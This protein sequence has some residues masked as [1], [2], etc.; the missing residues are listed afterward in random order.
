MKKLLI[1][2]VLT[3]IGST[4]MAQDL[5]IKGNVVDTVNKLPLADAVVM[6]VRLSDSVLLGFKRT[7]LKGEFMFSNL[8]VTTI[9]LLITH[10]KFDERSY[11]IIGTPEKKEFTVPEIILPSESQVFDEVV[12]FANN[13]PIYFRGDT[14]VYNADSFA[15]GQN[16]VVEDLLKKLPGI[17]VDEA[18]NITSQGKSI[19]QVLVDGDEFFGSDPT[20][21]TRNLGADG[22]ESVQVYEKKNEDAEDGDDE[23]IQVMDLKLKEDAK[24][25]Y[26]GRISGASDGDQT[27][28]IANPFYE[29][30]VLLNKFN[31]SQKISVFGLGSNTPRSSFGYRDM[32]KFGLDNESGGGNRWD[33]NPS[34]TSSGIPKTLRTGF[35][36]SDKIGKKTKIG[37][38]YSYYNTE[39]DAA[40][41]SLSQYFLTD[42]SYF[43]DNSA[44]NLSTN[45]SHRIN[46]KL[47]TDID[48]LTYLEIRPGITLDRATQNDNSF[49][50]FLTEQSDTTLNTVINNLNNSEGFSVNSRAKFR[51]KFKKEKRLLSIKYNFDMSDNESYGSLKST[52][53]YYDSIPY[54]DVIDQQKT[55]VNSSQKH[56]GIFTFTEPLSKKIKL[57]MEYEYAYGLS[58]LSI[59]SFNKINGEYTEFVSDN[60]NIFKNIRQENK[61]GAKLIYESK[62][63]TLQGGLRARNVAITNENLISDSIIFQ[64]IN[65]L[66]PNFLYTFKP[67]RSKRITFKYNTSSTQPSITAL[68]PVQNISDPNRIAIGNPDLVP[69]YRHTMNI[70]FNTWSALSGKYIWSGASF[71]I[72]DNAFANATSYDLYGR[73]ISQT[74]NVNGN[75]F[76]N[77]YGG[78][79]FP[80]YKRILKLNPNVNGSYNKYAGFINNLENIT[81]NTSISGGIELELDLDSLN[82]TIGNNMSY[83][84]AN[85][86]LYSNT[87]YTSQRYTARMK[88]QL[89]LHFIIKSDVSYTIN[90]QLSDGYNLNFFI[91]N[92][93]IS[94]AFL[95]TENLILSLVGNDILNQNV[96]AQRQVNGNVITDNRTTI[97]SRYF[98]LKLTMRFNNNKT[99]EKEPQ[100]WH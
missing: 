36:Y 45:E 30:E 84:Q 1:C 53:R 87:P 69:D 57:E 8:P 28:G 98:L 22:V 32:N 73:T 67:T 13:E 96:I 61:A 40:S 12:I 11:F 92:A 86:S 83:S 21:A 27:P 75:Q 7:D 56:T 24:K 78:A 52:T 68:Q 93:E 70:N 23:T 99:K 48:S 97:I 91:W 14:L 82:I 16:A 72:N 49:S 85:S 38:N 66:L 89:P 26:F 100:G 10:P 95:K 90:S 39:L 64:D 42:S 20:I 47:I 43:T 55:N 58:D 25:G 76:A 29:G 81:E 3:I 77:I 33:P 44:N 17:D 79:G 59:T 62:K 80:I 51:R 31:K 54:N 37:L 46:L 4:S 19:S 65:N 50:S 5:I 15:V 94:K 6:A 74:I 2:L 34:S 63:H 18:G 9:E 60:S 71:T 88:W 41:S 35:Y